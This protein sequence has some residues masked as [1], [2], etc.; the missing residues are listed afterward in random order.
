MTMRK[1]NVKFSGLNPLLMNNPQMADPLNGFKKKCATI[2][3]KGVRR[4]DEDHAHLGDLEVEAKVYFNDEL[5]VYIP[6][7]WIMASLCKVSNAVA[8][9]SKASI[10]SAVFPVQEKVKLYYL[11]DDIVKTPFDIVGNPAL[12]HKM[13]LPQG[14]V[15][16]PKHCP[17][18]TNW[19]F[20]FDLEY[21][22]TVADFADLERILK[23]GAKYG[24]FGDFRPTFGKAEAEV[25]NV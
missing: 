1:L 24:G 12:R 5:G 11:H 14:Q 19:S 17:M 8:K 6:A 2:T 23:Y 13:L 15:R 22:D 25:T 16:L 20:S 4:T 9:I 3:K 18:F 21:D 7:R 10:R